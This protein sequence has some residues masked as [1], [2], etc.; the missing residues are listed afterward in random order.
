MNLVVLTKNFGLNYTGAT[1]ATQQLI[2][3]WQEK[4][5]KIIVLTLHV[6][7][8]ADFNNRIVSVES[9]AD[10]ASLRRRLRELRDADCFYSD[11]HMGTLLDNYH[12]LVHTYHGNWP[13]GRHRSLMAMVK[14]LY[15]MPRYEH[16]FR[17][18]DK[19]VNVSHHMRN[20]TDKFTDNSM[21]IHNG[22]VRPV[23]CSHEEAVGSGL[24]MVGSVDRRK[25][26][27]LSIVAR[28]INEL[29]PEAAIDI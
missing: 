19:V 27:K 3:R 11:D 14:S 24:I 28:R 16:I 7:E 1:V 15:F 25:Y 4:L 8:C 2:V 29:K 26:G 12:P 23:L 20:Y 17:S 22:L 18:S 10:V 5:S 13:D 21:V 6:G 9:L